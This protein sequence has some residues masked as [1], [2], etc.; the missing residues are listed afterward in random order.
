MILIGLLYKDKTYI[1]FIA[2]IFFF[3]NQLFKFF[4]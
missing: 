1:S 4:D 2:V 3:F